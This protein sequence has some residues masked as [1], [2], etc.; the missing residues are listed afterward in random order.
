MS[1]IQHC[2]SLYVRRQLDLVG[3]FAFSPDSTLE[4]I[5]RLG[6]V[7]KRFK[8]EYFK[9]RVELTKG[10]PMPATYRN[11]RRRTDA[12]INRATELWAEV[13]GSVDAI[14]SI[15]EQVSRENH[16]QHGEPELV[17]KSVFG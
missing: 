16:L 12:A 9:A 1:F 3:L 10:M 4:H 2:V 13:N 8:D 7:E 11:Y 14:A 15:M 5:E 17:E 6:W